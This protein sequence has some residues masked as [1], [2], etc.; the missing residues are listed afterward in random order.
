VVQLCCLT[1]GSLKSKH[2]QLPVYFCKQNIQ[3]NIW[4]DDCWVGLFVDLVFEIINVRQYQL[5]LKNNMFL[6]LH[7]T[8]VKFLH[9]LTSF[10][11][12]VGDGAPIKDS[13]VIIIASQPFTLSLC[14]KLN[15]LSLV[16]L[17]LFWIPS[18]Y[19]CAHFLIASVCI[20]NYPFWLCW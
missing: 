5:R 11:F 9:I 15:E 12:Q 4:I 6:V 19:P 10:V 7:P 16:L 2:W 17:L 1:F 13:K 20:R 3:C 18:F 14:T 8:W